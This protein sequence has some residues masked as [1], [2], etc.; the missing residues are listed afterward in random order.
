MFSVNAASNNL[1]RVRFG[2]FINPAMIFRELTFGWRLY[3]E[4]RTALAGQIR[5]E[6]L[7]PYSQPATT[8]RR[9]QELND[10][11]RQPRQEPAHFYEAGIQ[12]DKAATDDGHVAFVEITKRRRPRKPAQTIGNYF[13]DITPLLHG[14]LRDA[15]QRLAVLIERGCV[16][17]YEDLLMR[18]NAAMRLDP[19]APGLVGRGV[20]PFTG[21]RR[22]DAGSP[23]DGS[24][25]NAV[26]PN[27]HSRVVNG[28]DRL[29]GS[30]FYA[31]ALQLRLSFAR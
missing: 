12:D 16:P 8:C 3:N 1:A 17:D 20:Q 18:R 11:T 24:A 9:K 30:Y 23:D 13:A 15:R 4:L 5:P 21:R 14:H 10:V 31:Q 7:C 27:D 19:H 29:S 25:G 2:G 6:P 26:V 22:R 28:G